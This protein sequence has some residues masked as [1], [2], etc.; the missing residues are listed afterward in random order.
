MTREAAGSRS[1]RQAASSCFDLSLSGLR[2]LVVED[3]AEARELVAATLGRLGATVLTAASAAT[4][5]EAL[6]VYRPD[7][8]VADIGMADEDGYQLIER[9]RLLPVEDGGA[10]PAIALTAYARP[11][12][13]DRALSA[14]YHEHLAKPV[15]ADELVRAVASLA[16]RPGA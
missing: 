11:E 6:R 16:R 2:V 3:E 9:I 8:L 13:R 10:T 1:A 15:T 4:G 7:L 5:Y 14:G 12:D